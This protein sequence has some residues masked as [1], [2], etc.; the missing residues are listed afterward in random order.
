MLRAVKT[1]ELSRLAYVQVG[2]EAMPVPEATA[3]L[4]LLTTLS[5]DGKTILS[6]P[7]EVIGSLRVMLKVY[8]V[9]TFTVAVAMDA[10]LVMLPGDAVNVCVLYILGKPALFV[11]LS[12]KLPVVS[13]DGGATKFVMIINN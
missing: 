1:M 13:V 4:V 2:A 5:T 9:A 11:M 7:A 8:E 3:Q 6:L 10:L 12:T